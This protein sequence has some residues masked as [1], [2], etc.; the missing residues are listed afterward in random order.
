MAEFDLQSMSKK[1]LVKLQKAVNKAIA[2]YDDRVKNEALAQ[3]EAKAREMGFS[4][5]ELTG[6]KKGKVASPPKYR[7]PDDSTQT[8]TGRGRQ[9]QWLK[10]AMAAGRNIEDMAI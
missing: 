1:E 7:N 10:D 6:G 5:A 9:P 3:L 8:W 4:L 2:E